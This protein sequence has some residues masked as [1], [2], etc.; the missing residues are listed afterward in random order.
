MDK[1][2]K[3]QALQ[4][5]L[6]ETR[7]KDIHIPDEH[8][9]FISLSKK[10]YGLNK[11]A[12]ECITEFH[13]PL[14]NKK[15]V[16]EELR[17]LLITDYWFY[18]AVDNPPQAFSTLLQLFDAL[19]SEKL[20][21]DLVKTALR[22]LLELI[23]KG[24]KD[25][26]SDAVTYSLDI[27]SRRLPKHTQSYIQVTGTFK[28]YLVPVMEIPSFADDSRK[29][30]QAILRE[31]IAF[32]KNTLH[33]Q[34]WLKNHPGIFSAETENALTHFIDDYLKRTAQ[35]VREAHT[36]QALQNTPDYEDIARALEEYAQRLP[37]FIEQFYYIFFLLQL[38]GMAE[39]QERL[40]W[41]VNKLLRQC[42][43]GTPKQPADNLCRNHLW[44]MLCHAGAPHVFR[45]R[46]FPHAGK[47]N[48]RP[49]HYR[50]Q[51]CYQ[52]F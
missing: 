26:F 25:D 7:Y 47:R 38:P 36:S 51:V 43:K 45:S 49:R 3:S 41:K 9:A 4:A 44:A 5:N 28:K 52:R 8:Q 1:D 29:L 34:Q 18:K 11:R 50:R 48:Y 16:T 32:W 35:K 31:N 13:H 22:T 2:F 42:I 14:S 33:L 37:T 39:W 23:Q 15:F 30:L 19:L 21:P 20:K 10:Y 46:H 12:Q 24:I 6:A 40:I 27:L 17:K